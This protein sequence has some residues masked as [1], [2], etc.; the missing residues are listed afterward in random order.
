[1]SLEGA[2]KL[3][4]EINAKD[5]TLKIYGGRLTWQVVAATTAGRIICRICWTGWRRGCRNGGGNRN[6]GSKKLLER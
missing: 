4:E 6:A 2:K 3:F 1:M 5:K